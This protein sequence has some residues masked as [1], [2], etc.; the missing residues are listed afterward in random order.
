MSLRMKAKVYES[1]GK[2]PEEI[3][4]L[5]IEEGDRKLQALDELLSKFIARSPT[6]LIVELIPMPSGD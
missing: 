2:S 3:L 6:E 4:A 1:Q 5:I